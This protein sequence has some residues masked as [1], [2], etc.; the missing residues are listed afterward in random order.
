MDKVVK[1][2]G[3]TEYAQKWGVDRATVRKLIKHGL[4]T[5]YNYKGFGKRVKLNPDEPPTVRRYRDRRSLKPHKES[6]APEAVLDSGKRGGGG[7][8][9]PEQVGP[10]LGLQ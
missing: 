10:E 4:L 9:T 6:R 7:S 1:L 8:M 2:V 3:I 5:I